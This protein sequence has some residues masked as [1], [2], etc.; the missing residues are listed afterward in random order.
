MCSLFYS[1]GLCACSMLAPH[2][3]DY[4]A[5]IISFQGGKHEIYHFV[6][7]F[8]ILFSPL[9]PLRSQIKFRMDFSTSENSTIGIL[10]DI[11]LNQYWYFSN[12]KSSI[13]KH[14]YPSFYLYL[15]YFISITCC[16]FHHKQLLLVSF[17]PKYFILFD[18]I[19]NEIVFMI[20]FFRVFFVS[21]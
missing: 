13:H 18:G 20:F 9:C 19:V 6:L 14:S 2:S 3:V 8:S 10:V 21:V 17:I 4:C 5:F 15:L 11:A 7:L 1:M 12:I 16:T